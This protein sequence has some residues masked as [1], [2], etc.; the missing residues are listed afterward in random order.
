MPTGV[1]GVSRTSARGSAR[2]SEDRFGRR[3]WRRRLLRMRPLLVLL[4]L[5]LVTGAGVWAVGFSSLLDART[6]AVRGLTSA[7]G[8]TPAQVRSAAAVPLRRPLARVDVAAVRTRIVAQL[9]PVKGAEV[10]R[11]WPHEVTVRIVERKAV[12]VWQ[13]GS[14]YHL[15]DADGVPFRTV[16]DAAGAH[17]L[18]RLRA[19]R[20]SPARTE[21]L[22]VVG[23]RVAAALPRS[24]LRRLDTIEVK[25][26]DAVTLRMTHGVTVV[27]GNAEQ[28][29]LKAKV[30]AELLPRKAKVYDVSVPGFPTTRA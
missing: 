19:G 18:V 21:E 17:P 28:S 8:L 9:P 23:A 25:T 29:K 12:A 4:A 16:P 24:L 2:R 15:V 13:D 14:A 27:W 7:S 5:V 11:S 22:R 3:R 1:S 20:P 30:L 6:V 10:S 26:P